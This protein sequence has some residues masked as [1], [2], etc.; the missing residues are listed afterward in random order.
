MTLTEVEE[1]L[2]S[3][4]NLEDRESLQMEPG[5]Q[6]NAL[7]SEVFTWATGRVLVRALFK[8]GRLTDKVWLPPG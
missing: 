2:G 1:V 7:V 8:D 6:V 3:E 5:F 4:G